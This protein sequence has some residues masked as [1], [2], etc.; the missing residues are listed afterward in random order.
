MGSGMLCH[1][2]ESVTDILGLVVG[3]ALWNLKK[4][5]GFTIGRLTSLSDPLA[6]SRVNTMYYTAPNKEL[7]NQ[8]EETPS[9]KLSLIMPQNDTV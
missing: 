4:V 3:R 7:I 2:S 6:D 9:I 1:K 8:S 5:S